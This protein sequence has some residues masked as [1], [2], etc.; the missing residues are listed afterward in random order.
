MSTPLKPF[1]HGFRN[2]G[3]Q[4]YDGI[5]KHEKNVNYPPERHFHDFYEFYLHIH[6]G[7]YMSI[8]NNIYT[9]QPGSFL[10]FPPFCMHGT[11]YD[12]DL[13]QYERLFFNVTPYA[14][15]TAGCGIIDLLSIIT[16]CVDHKYYYFNMDPENVQECVRLTKSIMVYPSFAQLSPDDMFNKHLI[17]LNFMQIVLK[18]IRMRVTIKQS[19]PEKQQQIQ[20]LFSYI[21][22]HFTEPLSLSSVA[23][24]F[25]ISISSLCHM[26]SH[27]T[28]RSMYEYMLYRRINYACEMMMTGKPLT[29]VAYLCGFNN[30][31][32]FMRIFKKIIGMTPSAY[33]KQNRNLYTD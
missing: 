7:Q 33:L 16:D 8:E 25:N 17:F 32:S 26:F 18:T 2:D 13:V 21:D 24:K 10:L 1:M 27:Y 23:K 30:Y 28:G 5:Y 29:N 14:L 20:L 15:M 12:H 31:S 19:V 4:L 11:I 3:L 22:Q 9:L 6:G